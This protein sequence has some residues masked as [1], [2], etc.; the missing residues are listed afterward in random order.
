MTEQTL[1]TATLDSEEVLIYTAQAAVSQ[2]NWVVG[3]CASRW[4]E[5]YAKGRTDADFG[6]LVGLSGDQVF[7]RRRVWEKF[8]EVHEKYEALKWSHYYVALN[9]DNATDCLE[10]ASET[11]STVAEMKAWRRAVLGEDL[12]KPADNTFDD[13]GNV[14]LQR[15]GDNELANDR[16]S[17][18]APFN[19]NGR[20]EGDD[21]AVQR[22]DS[23]RSMSATRDAGYA[24]F[25]ADAASP[26]PS[27]DSGD[28]AVMDRPRMDPEKLL[29]RM[30]RSLERMAEE[31][32]SSQADGFRKLPE[33]QRM[34]FVE[35]VANLSSKVSDTGL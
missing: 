24:P 10:W 1:G 30:T 23:E 26:A 4:T 32:S 19:V 14:P 28:A 22:D 34:R 6:N 9:W 5:R 11:E 18:S 15:V 3:D 27:S 35:A 33:K 25:R 20:D 29:K 31:L 12:T 2:C 13:W 21:S 7:Q 17:D 8:G 16:L